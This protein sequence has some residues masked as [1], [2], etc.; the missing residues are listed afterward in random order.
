MLAR[1]EVRSLYRRHKG[2]GRLARPGA[3]TRLWVRGKV[4]PREIPWCILLK[5]EHVW[6]DLPALAGQKSH[7]SACNQH[8]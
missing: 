4:H 3:C 5:D 7:F 1:K 8:V 6:Q 2:A